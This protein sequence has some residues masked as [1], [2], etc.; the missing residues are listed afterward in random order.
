[1]GSRSFIESFV[2]LVFHEDLGTISNL[3]MLIN[4]QTTFVML[5]L[6]Y[7]QCPGYLLCIVFPSP[8]I[9]QHCIEFDIRTIITLEK[10]LGVDLLGVLSIT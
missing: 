9:L 1:V 5:L 4:L 2:V 3:P 10:L 7:A 8:C 6:C